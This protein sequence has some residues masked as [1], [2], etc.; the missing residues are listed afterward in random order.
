M[1][2]FLLTASIILFAPHLAIGAIS[3][4]LTS[5]RSTITEED[6]V[7]MRVILSGS[8]ETTRPR[9]PENP[10]FDVE[11]SGVSSQ[12][13]II[14]G[15]MQAQT[16]FSY[17]VTPKK[18][19]TMTVGPATVTIDGKAYHSQPLVISV[20]SASQ[21]T[22]QQTLHFLTA[23]VDHLQPYVHQQVIY[24]IKFYN[25]ASLID[26]NLNSPD[27]KGFWQEE[28]GKQKKYRE[29]KHGI[30]WE[31]IEIRMA[32]FPEKAGKIT[33][34]P[35]KLDLN[36]ALKERNRHSF[37]SDSFF[38]TRRSKKVK[39]K[40]KSIELFV[41]NL[42]EFNAKKTKNNLVG[43]NLQISAVLD[44]NKMKQGESVTLT[45]SLFGQANIWDAQLKDLTLPHFKLYADKPTLEK[46]MRKGKLTTRKDFKFALV[47]LKQGKRQIPS[48]ELSYFDPENSQ[49]QTIK[50]TPIQLDVLPSEQQE[51]LAHVSGLTSQNARKEVK[52]LG[53]DLMPLKTELSL[54]KNNGFSRTGWNLLLASGIFCA[55][56][57]VLAFGYRKRIDR[58]SQDKGYLRREKAYGKFRQKIQMETSSSNYYQHVSTTLR[59]FIG[60]KCGIEGRAITPKDITRILGPRGVEKETLEKLIHLLTRLEKGQYGGF[61]VQAVNKEEMNTELLATAKILEQ[62]VK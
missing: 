24:T 62:R 56:F 16:I 54:V 3:L 60:D 18:T 59:E 13:Q 35:T 9:F 38:S 25:R 23:T 57:H 14:N 7:Q 8:Q 33:I 15:R 61:S 53:A 2:T 29:N 34:E 28:L 10:H 46:R 47:P 49:Y 19:G 58:I 48:I 37:F 11:Y 39:L 50:T 17:D 43:Q 31:V 26:A 6:Q 42:P 5:S 41:Q 44:K 30:N 55:F 4:Q 32:L 27:F 12:V 1:K 45:V 51:T 21:K 52:V 22:P 36:I 20:T 40:T